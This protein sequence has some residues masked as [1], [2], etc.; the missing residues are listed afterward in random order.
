MKSYKI[1]SGAIAVAILASL[2]TVIYTSRMSS[3]IIQGQAIGL[4]AE[5]I[6]LERSLGAE[7]VTIDSVELSKGG[8][9]KFKIKNNSSDP[10]LYELRYGW[11]RIPLF[12]KRGDRIEISSIGRFALNYN[13]EGSEESTM[14]REFYQPYVR[15]GDELRKIATRYAEAEQAGED[16][17]AAAKE[18]A[19]IYHDI[20]RDQISF[21]ISHKGD[22]AAIYALSQRLPGDSYLMSESSDLIYMRTVADSVSQRYPNSPYIKLL[23]SDIKDIELRNELLNS[24]LVRTYPELDMPDMYGKNVKLSSLDGKVI[25]IDFWSA[26]L[27]RGNQNNAEMKEM[28]K[29]LHDRGLEIYQVAVDTSKPLWINAIQQQHLPWISVS[30][31][32]GGNSSALG[33]Y[34][35]TTLPS[36]II[37]SRDG[38]IVGRN[39]FGDDLRNMIEK[40]L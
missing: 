32:R 33:L 22:M 8:E 21:I 12:G 38:M 5:S 36:N 11:D 14:L 23:Q 26:E 7:R 35:V 24:A 37:I 15:K 31:L 18:Y 4:K 10:T 19:K 13:V 3:L 6:Y 40:E 20:K 1:L 30:D 2:G 16:T 27:G 9:F 34:N 28:Y 39:I 25:V 29:S 17:N